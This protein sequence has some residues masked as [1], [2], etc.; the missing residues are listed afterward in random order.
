[1]PPTIAHKM[2]VDPSQQHSLLQS[3]VQ[4]LAQLR[5][6]ELLLQSTHHLTPHTR[7][8]WTICGP[9]IYSPNAHGLC[10]MIIC[11]S[12]SLLF[13]LWRSERTAGPTLDRVVSQCASKANVCL[14]I[15]IRIRSVR[16]ACSSRGRCVFAGQLWVGNRLAT[17]VGRTRWVSA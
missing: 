10:I 2:T 9:S 14:R 8:L 11:T 13:S 7:S 17:Y 12:V 4:V 5:V 3:L 15:I 1:M 16:V 6:S